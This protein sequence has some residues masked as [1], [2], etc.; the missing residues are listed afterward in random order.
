MKLYLVNWASIGEFEAEKDDSSLD[1]VADLAQPRV[2]HV[3]RTMTDEDLRKI[4]E[5]VTDDL[6]HQLGEEYE[7]E[8]ELPFEPQDF[9]F[10]DGGWVTANHPLAKPVRTIEVYCRDTNHI[11]SIVI[12][13]LEID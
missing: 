9:V 12:A 5:M 8:P 10:E 3:T 6:N 7:D 11:A 1:C 4:R 2:S 13:E